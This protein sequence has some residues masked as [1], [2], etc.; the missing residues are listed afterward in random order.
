MHARARTHARTRTHASHAHTRARALTVWPQRNT[1]ATM[2]SSALSRDSLK[3]T[4]P[5]A[6]PS[7]PKYTMLAS[8]SSSA[9]GPFSCTDAERRTDGS[10]E[11]RG[12]H[13]QTHTRNAQRGA[14][15]REWGRGLVL[16]VHSGESQCVRVRGR[17]DGA[18]LQQQPDTKANEEGA[19]RE[20]RQ[21]AATHC[22][23]VSSSCRHAASFPRF[24]RVLRPI[25]TPYIVGISG[26]AGQVGTGRGRAG[27]RVARDYARTWFEKR[28]GGASSGS[29]PSGSASLNQLFTCRRPK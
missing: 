4:F 16:G 20:R 19:H 14:T 17:L 5:K 25:G 3:I 2:K 6:R 7:A 10:K 28:G 23:C 15:C 18:S 26:A 29:M 8:D 9:D 22:C 24:A 27:W 12:R 11:R 21:A 1:C 13:D